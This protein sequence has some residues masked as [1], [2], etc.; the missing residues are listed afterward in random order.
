M[1][2]IIDAEPSSY[3]KATSLSVWRGSMMEEYHS[4]IGNGIWD[5]VPIP[6]GKSIVTSK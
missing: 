5:M 2:D 6:E 3:E 1:S 4:I